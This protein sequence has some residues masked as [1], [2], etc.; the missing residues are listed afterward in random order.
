MREARAPAG[1]DLPVLALDVVDDGRGRPGKQRRH[2]QTDAFARARGRKGQDVFRAFVAQVLAIV[3]AEEH[4]G[5]L[6]EAGSTNVL[7]VRPACRAVGRNQP[8]LARAPDRHTDGDHHRQ[9]AAAAR[10]GAAG[11]EHAGRV[12]IEEEPPLEQFPR[13]VDRRAKKIEPGR[14][15]A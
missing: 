12:G 15:K 6:C 13:V 14:A 5:R 7:R 10:D 4:P 2:H 3:L 9:Q 11:I 1:G 8:R